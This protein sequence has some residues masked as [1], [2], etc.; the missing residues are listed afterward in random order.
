MAEFAV[1]SAGTRTLY[2]KA[3]RIPTFY[4]TGEKLNLYQ[5]TGNRMYRVPEEGWMWGRSGEELR[6]R[7]GGCAGLGGEGGGRG[8]Q[9]KC[10]DKQMV[11]GPVEF[12]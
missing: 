11:P 12:Y 6:G 10:I 5:T 1:S 7:S 8:G 2:N 4:N 3:D 9:V